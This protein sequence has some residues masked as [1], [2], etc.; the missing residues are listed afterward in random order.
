MFRKRQNGLLYCCD[1]AKR[2]ASELSDDVAVPIASSELDR[3]AIAG[4][5]N[6]S[7]GNNA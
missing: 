7:R 6:K 3:D 4:D 2:K 1:S 5:G